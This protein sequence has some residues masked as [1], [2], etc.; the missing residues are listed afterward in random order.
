MV[1]SESILG[2]LMKR[3][4]F[5]AELFSKEDDKEIY[6]FVNENYK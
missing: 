6:N 2:V 1:L 4:T 3:T 5:F